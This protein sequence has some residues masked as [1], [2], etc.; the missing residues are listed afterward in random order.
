MSLS[1]VS[2]FWQAVKHVIITTTASTAEITEIN[3]FDLFIR[4]PLN[5][6][7]NFIIQCNSNKKFRKTAR[8]FRK[9]AEF[10]D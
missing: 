4:S 6:K 10:D 2:S 1:G 9:S 5:Y 7:F 8:L 3:F